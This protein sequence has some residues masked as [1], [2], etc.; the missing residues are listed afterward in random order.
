MKIIDTCEFDDDEIK[1]VVGSHHKI[2]IEKLY[3]PCCVPNVEISW[4]KDGWVFKKIDYDKGNT[5]DK[6]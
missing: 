5:N 2:I 1:L 4:G 3:G 6:L